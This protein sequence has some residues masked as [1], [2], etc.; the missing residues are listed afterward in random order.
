VVKVIKGEKVQMTTNTET[1]G[2]ESLETKIAEMKGIPTLEDLQTILR[3]N[4]V[5]VT[6]TKL[7]GD[8]RIMD[9]TKSFNIIP[10]EHH[11]KTDKQSKEGTVTVWDVNANGWRSFKYDRVKSIQVL[12][13]GE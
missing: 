3:E 5:K 9:C 1:A 8:E 7:D 13:A 6:F 10:Q 12:D 4:K 11:P 2:I